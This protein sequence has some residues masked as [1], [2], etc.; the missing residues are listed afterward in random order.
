MTEKDESSS[1][2]WSKEEPIVG[3]MRLKAVGMYVHGKSNSG[4]LSREQ[5]LIPPPLQE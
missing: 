1:S 4:I 3:E 5:A 2:K